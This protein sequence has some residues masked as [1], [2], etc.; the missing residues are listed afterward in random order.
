VSFP[1]TYRTSY[2]GVTGFSPNGIA[3]APN[4]T[5]YLDTFYGN[6]YADRSAL[7]AIAPGGHAS[8]LWTQG[9]PKG[10]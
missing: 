1:T 9:P 10:A 2:L 5:V 4:G 6:G 3:V 7:V 8:L